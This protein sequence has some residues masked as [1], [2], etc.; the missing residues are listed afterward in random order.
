LGTGECKGWKEGETP[1]GWT[2]EQGQ[3]KGWNDQNVPPGF[4]TK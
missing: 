4:Q 3:R 2:N 1:P